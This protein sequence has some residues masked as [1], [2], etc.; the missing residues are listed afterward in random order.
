MALA[1]HTT[2][3]LANNR[4]SGNAIT[5]QQRLSIGVRV[6]L[7]FSLVLII[8]GAVALLTNKNLQ[9]FY[10]MFGQYSQVS[11]EA[12]S[13]FEIDRKVS[14]LQRYIL[15]F[16]HT[17]QSGAIDHARK[18]NQEL[19]NKLSQALSAIE[20]K[21]RQ[22]VVARM[23]AILRG[24]SENIDT[25]V[26]ERT[27]TDELIKNK[28]LDQV[29][30]FDDEI[31]SVV[32]KAEESGYTTL[33]N[34]GYLVQKKFSQVE[35]KILLLLYD[36]RYGFLEEIKNVFSELDNHVAELEIMRS[37]QHKKKKDDHLSVLLKEYQD[38][39]Y[40]AVQATRGYS[41]LVNVVLAGEAAEFLTLSEILRNLTVEAMDASTRETQHNIL[42]TQNLTNISSLVA[43]V[44][45]F[46]L[47]GAIGASITRPIKEIT[48]AVT[49][50]ANGENETQIPG[51]DRG[52][53]IGQIAR[54]ADVFKDMY[55]R[56][57]ELLLDSQRLAKDLKHRELSLE[58]KTAELQKSNEELD[59]FAYVA[60][61]DLKSPLRAIDN[62]SLWIEDDCKELLPSA[63]LK[64]L[65]KLRQRVRRMENLLSDLL[66]YSRVGRVETDIE[67]VD[68]KALL[69][70]TI[71][72]IDHPENF[73]FKLPEEM[74][75][76]DTQVSPL[77][78][79]F[80]NLMTNAVKYNDKEQGCVTVECKEV[81]GEMIEF[82][83]A[84]NGPGIEPR[85]HQRIFQMFQTLQ[86]RDV[87]ES[88]GMGLAIIKKVLE[89]LGGGISVES[90]LDRG[91]LFRFTWP[92]VI[93]IKEEVL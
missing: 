6:Y 35:T 7:G 92:K 44:L 50:L 15:I 19:I 51:L 36:R 45:G 62:L 88:S 64:H 10:S 70:D 58:E 8:L 25:L 1:K 32:L 20:D 53:E 18:I 61:H 29:N 42:Y 93:M 43:L 16:S 41:F 2:S 69:I 87:I 31:L 89:S 83:I 81:E 40:R 55:Q 26:E 78:Q 74:P 57:E 66:H 13:I 60:S 11:A 86:S 59:N 72:L 71:E 28:M 14:D 68:V 49:R 52:D 67:S 33:K 30:V 12:T 37:V 34:Q 21:E 38:S 85:Y 73:I 91:A 84:D 77:Q 5:S 80:M 54:A 56:T 3:P 22:E 75:K 82:S 47:A 24:Y 9:V 65:D 27:F 90:D 4:T 39:F 76:I 48:L 79:V 63:S 17:G 23:S 46:A